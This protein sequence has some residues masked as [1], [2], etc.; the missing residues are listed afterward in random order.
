MKTNLLKNILLV[1]SWIAIATS[2]AIFATSQQWTSIQANLVNLVQYLNELHITSDGTPDGDP[3]MH[4]DGSGNFAQIRQEGDPQYGILNDST[5][6]GMPYVGSMAGSWDDGHLVGIQN[7]PWYG[8]LSVVASMGGTEPWWLNYLGVNNRWIWISHIWEVWSGDS[9]NSIFVDADGIQFSFIG[10]NKEYRFPTDAWQAN[11]VLT[12]DG[13]GQL[14]W[15]D[16]AGGSAS[17]T[18]T[19][20]A[21][22]SFSDILSL[23]TNPIVLI[24]APGAGKFIRL[25]DASIKYN[26][27][28]V[29]Y[30]DSYYPWFYMCIT[31]PGVTVTG[32]YDCVA[33]SNILI[34]PNSS[35]RGMTFNGSTEMIENEPLQ[36]TIAD[37][38]IGDMIDVDLI[39]WDGTIDIYLTYKIIDL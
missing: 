11:Q 34:L 30:Q 17:D 5:T 25:I 3:V 4:I 16:A 8:L 13:A 35:L 21:Q 18:T 26:F 22:L 19:T 6:L 36:I 7:I 14:S 39:A 32:Y 28:S 31:Y 24:P 33:A 23:D 27:G 1:W 37:P 15:A 29:S 20:T 10:A 2:T 9:D 38:D 12:T